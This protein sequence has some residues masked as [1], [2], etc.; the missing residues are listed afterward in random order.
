MIFKEVKEQEP[1]WKLLRRIEVG[2]VNSIMLNMA[3]T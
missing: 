2:E 3:T 1:A